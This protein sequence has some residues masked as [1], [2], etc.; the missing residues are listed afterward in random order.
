ML[1]SSKQFR[2]GFPLMLVVL[3]KDWQADRLLQR[4]LRVHSAPARLRTMTALWN[5]AYLVSLLWKP[6]SR[7]SAYLGLY[8]TKYSYRL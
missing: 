7:D 6:P 1:D 3:Y 2:D 5:L 8:D 4:S